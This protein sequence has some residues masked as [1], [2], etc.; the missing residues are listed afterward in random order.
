MTEQ[1]FEQYTQRRNAILKEYGKKKLKS[2]LTVLGIGGAVVIAI[3]VIGGL[4]L[5]N[6][7]VTA[8]LALIAGIFTILYTR[9]RVVTINHARQKKLH[10][11]EDEE[12]LKKI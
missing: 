12:L 9:I 8:V 5:E 2:C 3:L 11:F 1:A 7:P 10:Q 6:I 4:V